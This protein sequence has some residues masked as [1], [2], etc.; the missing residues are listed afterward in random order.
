MHIDDNYGLDKYV[1][2]QMKK[3]FLRYHLS[4]YQLITNLCEKFKFRMACLKSTSMMEN[5]RRACFVM[6]G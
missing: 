4:N 2:V 5:V 3:Y 1:R 6:G